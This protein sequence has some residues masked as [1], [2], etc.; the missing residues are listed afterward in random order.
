MHFSEQQKKIILFTEYSLLYFVCGTAFVIRLAFIFFSLPFHLNEI[1]VVAIIKKNRGKK[2]SIESA[3]N[4]F[5][6]IEIKLFLHAEK[7]FS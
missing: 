5:E 4:L 7:R 3:S 6:K 1:I 2:K